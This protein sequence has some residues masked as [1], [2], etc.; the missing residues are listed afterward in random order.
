MEIIFM[1]QLCR[2]QTHK[3]MSATAGGDGDGH[4]ILKS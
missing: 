2:V 4:I 3:H 1:T